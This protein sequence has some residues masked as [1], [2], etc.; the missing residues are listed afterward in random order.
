MTSDD[1]MKQA[2]GRIEKAAGDLTG[3]EQLRQQGEMDE[4]K[5]KMSEKIADLR[6]KADQKIDS[7]REKI[8]K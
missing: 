5:G 8:K 7:L 2:K 1:K 6:E 4:S 3:D